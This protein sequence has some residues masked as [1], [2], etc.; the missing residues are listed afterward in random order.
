MKLIHI[1]FILRSTAHLC[2]SLLIITE[3]VNVTF[4]LF[5]LQSYENYMRD[6]ALLFFM[7]GIILPVKAI[8]L[9][10]KYR[11]DKLSI[12]ILF[13][14]SHQRLSAFFSSFPA[15]RLDYWF[16]FPSLEKTLLRCFYFSNVSKSKPLLF[17]CIFQLKDHF[18]LYLFYFLPCQLSLRFLLLSLVYNSILLSELLPFIVSAILYLLLLFST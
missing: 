11:L 7:V 14:L 3:F 13:I 8:L 18:Y 6:R 4:Q 10:L 16:M 2:S 17:H 12:S 5:F 9:P 1:C 15:M